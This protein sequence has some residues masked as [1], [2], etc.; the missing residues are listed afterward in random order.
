VTGCQQT[1]RR[2]LRPRGRD[3]RARAPRPAAG[4][5]R[6]RRRAARPRARAPR[7][8]IDVRAGAED[9]RDDLRISHR[10]VTDEPEAPAGGDPAH[11]RQRDLW[12]ER[13]RFADGFPP[14]ALVHR[15]KDL[16]ALRI[17]PRSDEPSVVHRSHPGERFERRDRHD[18]LSSGHGE[19]LH[20]RDADPEARERSRAG[21]DGEQVHGPQRDA[22]LTDETHQLAGQPLPVGDR[23]IARHFG[24][25]QAVAEDGGA[26]GTPGGVD[27]EHNHAKKASGLN[28]LAGLRPSEGL[29]PLRS[30]ASP[31][32]DSMRQVSGS[33]GLYSRLRHSASTS[34]QQTR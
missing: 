11:R 13:R 25:H 6:A 5:R 17:D 1:V 8:R 14:A 31:E 34:F 10:A 15:S 28:V 3:G 30:R 7:L 24:E 33:Q 29:G 18:G 9:G 26:S 2:R 32:L 23:R 4:C 12:R 27:R 19:P 16:A 21:G 20:G 22:S